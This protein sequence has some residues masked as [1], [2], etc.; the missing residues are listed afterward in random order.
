MAEKNRRIVTLPYGEGLERSKGVMVVRPQTF[1]DIR[2]MFLFDGKAQVRDGILTR[3]VLHDDQPADLDV[4]VLLEPLRSLSASVGVGYNRTGTS[5]REVWLNRMFID[6]TGPV[7]IGQ[8]GTLGGDATFVPP[9]IIGADS[10]NKFFIAHDEPKFSARF[11][12]QVFDPEDFPQ[13]RN[14]TADLVGNGAFSDVFFRGVVRHLSYIFGWGFGNAEDPVRGDVVRVSN[15]GNSSVF[16][17]FAFF[18]AGQQGETVMVCRSA[19]PSLM[20]FK[21]TETYEIFGYSPDTFGIR[22]ADS[23]FGC[24]GS[25]LAVSVAGN[26]FFW[27]T[28]G[29]RVTTGGPSVDIAVPLDIDG[30]DPATLVAESE[31]QDAFAA[32]DPRTRVVKFVWGR[33]VYA[34]SIRDPQKPRW[35]YYELAETAQ[36]SGLF[37]STQSQAGQGGPPVGA[38][39]IDTFDEETKGTLTILAANANN[40]ETVFIHNKLYVWQTVLTDVDGNVLIGATAQ[41]SADNLIAAIVLGAGAGVVYAA[42]MTINSDFTAGPGADPNTVLASGRLNKGF[43]G[44][45][46]ALQETMAS[47][48]WNSPVSIDGI[49]QTATFVEFFIENVGAL[50]GEDIEIHVSDDGG[51]NYTFSGRVP[52]DGSVPPDRQKLTVTLEARSSGR[53]IQPLTNYKFSI[54]YILGG[55]FSPGYESVD[56]DDWPAVSQGSTVTDSDP[57]VLGER[58]GENEGLWESVSSSD[59]QINILTDLPD[60]HELIDIEV[61]HEIQEAGPA[62]RPDGFPSLGPPLPPPARGVVILPSELDQIYN[63]SS[64]GFPVRFEDRYDEDAVAPE[65]TTEKLNIYKMRYRKG[66]NIGPFTSDLECYLGPDAPPDGSITSAFVIFRLI[67]VFG[68]RRTLSLNWNNTNT[69]D[70]TAAEGGLRTCPAPTAAGVPPRNHSTEIYMRNVDTGQLWTFVTRV[71]PNGTSLIDHVLDNATWPFVPGDEMHVAIRHRVRCFGVPFG[72]SGVERSEWGVQGGSQ[73]FI[74]VFAQA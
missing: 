10:D 2:N 65:P 35:S 43:A 61:F 23:L 1:D 42:S 3:S 20:V 6:G 71:G 55:Q 60:G 67:G 45:G 54:R 40:N 32:Y 47:G 28:Q 29:P 56:P 38:P 21:E 63:A 69:P 39:E 59:H 15:S 33:R 27:S 11:P 46:S 7:D 70:G 62:T 48:S 18:E 13:L 12:T 9:I 68:V 41:D 64:P 51:S 50:G 72:G 5:N 24:V 58:Q 53:R 25:R 4:T 22:L 36:C 14:L 44:N 31:P 8:L 37:F 34:L 66:G 17:D 74:T 52:A 16:E 19:G 49:G 57:I 30:P 26:V 73:R